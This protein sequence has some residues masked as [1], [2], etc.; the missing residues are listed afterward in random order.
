MTF[1][2]IG[3]IPAANY[4]EIVKP[5]SKRNFSRFFAVYN[6]GNEAFTP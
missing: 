5:S 6:T 4:E 3:E 2:S 1:L